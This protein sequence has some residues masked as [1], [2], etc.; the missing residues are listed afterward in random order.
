MRGC[1]SPTASPGAS[2]NRLPRLAAEHAASISYRAFGLLDLMNIVSNRPTTSSANR[3]TPLLTCNAG[4]SVN[5]VGF[6]PNPYMKDIDFAEL[7]RDALIAIDDGSEAR[8]N[9]AQ[10]DRRF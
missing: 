3:F 9:P 1:G 5:Q 8:K 4:P 10:G 7:C 6:T 2:P